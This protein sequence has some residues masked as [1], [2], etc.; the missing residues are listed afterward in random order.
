MRATY[1]LFSRVQQQL[2][3]LNTV[4]QENLSGVRV[5]RAFARGEHEARRFGGTNDVLMRRNIALVRMT[6]VSMPL[7][8]LVLTSASWRRC[9]SAAC[10]SRRVGCR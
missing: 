5:V 2:D 9:G 6:A 1:P 3:A 10:V 7:M 8:M 4:M